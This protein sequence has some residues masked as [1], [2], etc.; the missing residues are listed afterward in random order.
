MQGDPLSFRVNVLWRAVIPVALVALVIGATL[1]SVE[2]RQCRTA[3]EEKG[4][5][6]YR[7]TP[8]GRAGSPHLCH[9]L[10]RAESEMKTIVPKGT[11][12]FPWVQ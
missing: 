4:F 8:P 6:S 2:N 11:L 12:V 5:Y 10:T 3:C 1:V 9:C 7:Y